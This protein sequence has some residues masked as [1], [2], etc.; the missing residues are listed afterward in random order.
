MLQSQTHSH[1][2]TAPSRPTKGGGKGRR[3]PAAPRSDV[4]ANLRQ[5]HDVS[6]PITAGQTAPRMPIPG[7]GQHSC[8]RSPNGRA[9]GG[10]AE[11]F[12]GSN[13]KGHGDNGSW[14]S[15]LAQW[16]RGVPGVPAHLALGG[17]KR[18]KMHPPGLGVLLGDSEGLFCCHRAA[19]KLV[20]RVGG[21]GWD[22]CGCE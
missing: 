2:R 16:P 3:T 4:S 14:K 5:V 7:R 18:T 13:K 19:A 21:P 6:R 12:Q 20:L 10:G 11:C 9:Q 15:A 1:L 17:L 22:G 8:T